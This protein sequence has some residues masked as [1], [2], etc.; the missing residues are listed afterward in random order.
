MS[1]LERALVQ[2]MQGDT[3]A[4]FDTRTVP[5]APPPQ[6]EKAPSIMEMPPKP[7]ERAVSTH[8]K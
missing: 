8:D 7:E 1:S 2:Y 5:A 4:P 3:T 6:E